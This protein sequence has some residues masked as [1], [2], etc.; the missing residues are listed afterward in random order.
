MNNVH[1]FVVET[2]ALKGFWGQ[3]FKKEKPMLFFAVSTMCF[4]HHTITKNY[5]KWTCFI[6]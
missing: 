4:K 3:F 5:I 1:T 6:G 2:A